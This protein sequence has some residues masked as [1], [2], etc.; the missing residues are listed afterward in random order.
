M[1]PLFA[2][3]ICVVFA[4]P[5]LADR[6]DAREVVGVLGGAIFD[7]GVLHGDEGRLYLDGEPDGACRV[8][9]TQDDRHFGY[10]YRIWKGDRSVAFATIWPM[11]SLV[12]G[13]Y[14]QIGKRLELEATIENPNVQVQR[15]AIRVV[16]DG[17]RLEVEISH[18]FKSGHSR[19]V[20]CVID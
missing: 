17:K 15:E 6:L 4:S 7:D 13:S 16:R 1:K 2:G 8:A 20:A 12:A 9:K 18:T 11:R 14:S 19:S 3:L 5:A 10:V